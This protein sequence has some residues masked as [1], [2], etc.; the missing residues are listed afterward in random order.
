M[1]KELGH[2]AIK[3]ILNK[4][5][6]SLF[7]AKYRNRPCPIRTILIEAEISHAFISSLTLRFIEL[8][9]ICEDSILLLSL[10]NNINSKFAIVSE[11]RTYPGNIA[12]GKIRLTVTFSAVES[13][14]EIEL[15]AYQET[16]VCTITIKLTSFEAGLSLEECIRKKR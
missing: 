15:R 11:K 4:N 1:I 6:T 5:T 7:L 12:S 8:G 3:A 14:L 16:L 2:E 13:N 9:D 10:L